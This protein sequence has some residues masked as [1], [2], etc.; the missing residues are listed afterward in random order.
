MSEFLPMAILVFLL[1]LGGLETAW[2]LFTRQAVSLA[3][4]EAARA[5]STQHA[6]PQAIAAAFEAGLLPLHAGAGANAAAR[7][8]ASLQR[9]RSQTGGPPWRIEILQPDAGSFRRHGAPN[10]PLAKSTGMP[11]ID[12]DYQY[13]QYRLNPVVPPDGGTIY[14]ANTLSLRLTYLHRPLLPG[15]AVLLRSIRPETGGYADEAMRHGLLPM[16]RHLQLG[17]ESHPLQW[18]GLP[19]GRVVMGA[20]KLPPAAEAKPPAFSCSGGWCLQPQQAITDPT[21]GGPDSGGSSP[22]PPLPDEQAPLPGGHGTEPSTP[23]GEPLPGEDEF[24]VCETGM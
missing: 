10:L 9:H 3:L 6:S 2:W 19:D 12:N 23:P 14:Q 1:G 8:Q 22:T 4:L 24:P 16:M 18:P 21:P 17:M 15:I 20:A 11:A 13:E 5:G 7:L